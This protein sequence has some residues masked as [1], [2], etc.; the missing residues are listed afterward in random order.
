MTKGANSTARII[1][2]G[3]DRSVNNILLK[4]KV[5]QDTTHVKY[6][7]Y[8]TFERDA[9]ISLSLLESASQNIV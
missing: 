8:S 3:C 5:H 1:R 2:Q 9:E 7:H 4:Y 6:I